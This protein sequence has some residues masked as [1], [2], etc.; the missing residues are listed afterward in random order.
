MPSIAACTSAVGGASGDVAVALADAV[1]G[2]L[3]AAHRQL[4]RI[5]A[6]IA[7][8]DAAGADRGVEDGKTVAGHG[9]LQSWFEGCA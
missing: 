9:W 2:L 5:D 6:A 1:A 7:P 8:R 3:L 4:H